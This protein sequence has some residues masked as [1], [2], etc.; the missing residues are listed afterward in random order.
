MV[1]ISI[2]LSHGITEF[3]YSTRILFYSIVFIPPTLFLT[4]IE[5]TID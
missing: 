1:R 5:K 3:Q 4:T 2:S